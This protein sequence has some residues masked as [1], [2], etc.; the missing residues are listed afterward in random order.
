MSFKNPELFPTQ[1]SLS[2]KQSTLVKAKSAQYNAANQFLA[3]TIMTGLAILGPFSLL[4]PN[5]VR[6]TKNLLGKSRSI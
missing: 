5:S 4:S 3:I 2:P 1:V 6:P